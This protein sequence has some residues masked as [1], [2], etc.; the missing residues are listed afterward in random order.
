MN[1]QLTE[2]ERILLRILEEG[3]KNGRLMTEEELIEKL[4]RIPGF[5]D[6]L[7]AEERREGNSKQTLDN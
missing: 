1:N 3:T 7:L 6:R 5:Y 2:N 4:E